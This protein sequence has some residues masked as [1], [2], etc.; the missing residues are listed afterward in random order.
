MGGVSND[1]PHM[2]PESTLRVM[3]H[4]AD[5]GDSLMNAWRSD[6]EEITGMEGMLGAGELGAAFTA[7]YQQA[8]IVTRETADTSPE[9]LRLLAD[10][11]MQ[12]AGIYVTGDENARSAMP[13]GAEIPRRP[14]P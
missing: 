10:A 8:A 7:G 6:R 11:G 2:D 12:S 14:L 13:E 3:G 1:G 4:L 5:V 9:V